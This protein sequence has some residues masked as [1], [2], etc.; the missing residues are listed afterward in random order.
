MADYEIIARQNDAEYMSA[1]S[2]ILNHGDMR[3][4][5]RTGK[6]T[7]SVVGLQTEYRIKEMEDGSY[8]VPLISTRDINWKGATE[9]IFWFCNMKALGR[10]NVND[11]SFRYWDAWADENGDLGH[12]YG[13]AWDRSIED[14]SRRIIKDPTCRR[15]MVN[16]WNGGSKASSLPPCVF[17]WQIYKEQGG[18]TMVVRQRSCD[19]PVG[20]PFNIYQYSA[21]LVFICKMSGVRPIRLVHQVGDA[22]IYEDQVNAVITMLDG[23]EALGSVPRLTVNNDSIQDT[24]WTKLNIEGYKPTMKLKIPVAV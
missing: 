20:A 21:L 16:A 19:F 11:V 5:E 24:D 10:A 6:M 18:F 23:E 15:N 4:N 14:V 8:I 22:H 2:H 17:N 9:E 3:V 7:H 1:L 12:T 13:L